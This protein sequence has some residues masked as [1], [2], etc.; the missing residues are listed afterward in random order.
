MSAIALVVEMKAKPGRRPALLARLRRHR[1]NVLAHEPGCQ[2]F[3]ILLAENDDDLF[4]YEV[5][6]DRQALEDHGRTDH[7]QAYRSDTDAMIAERRR[8]VCTLA[9]A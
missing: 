4:L 2:R 1:E 3:D 5:Y 8:A 6:A 7:F 9:T